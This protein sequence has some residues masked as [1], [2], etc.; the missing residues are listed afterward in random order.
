MPSKGYVPKGSRKGRGGKRPHRSKPSKA[1]VDY[2][3]ATKDGTCSSGRWAWPERAGAKSLLRTLRRNGDHGSR[4]YRCPECNLFHVGHLPKVVR[5]GDAG[6]G[7]VY[8]RNRP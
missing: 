8:P 5:D 4:V 3:G 6:A 1:G 7:E 2:R